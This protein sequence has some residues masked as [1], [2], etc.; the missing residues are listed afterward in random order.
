MTFS[1]PT[2]TYFNH[3]YEHPVLWNSDRRRYEEKKLSTECLNV[4]KRKKYFES[5]QKYRDQLQVLQLFTESL[6]SWKKLFILFSSSYTIHS[7]Q[8]NYNF[9]HNSP[10]IQLFLHSTRIIKKGFICRG[11]RI[12]I[13]GMLIRWLVPGN[14]RESLFILWNTAITIGYDLFSRKSYFM[15]Q[16]SNWVNELHHEESLLLILIFIFMSSHFIMLKVRRSEVNRLKIEIYKQILNLWRRPVLTEI[17]VPIYVFV[18]QTS[19][20]MLNQGR[21]AIPR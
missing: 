17:S 15:I 5:L 6:I 19:N 16:F 14:I 10:F 13:Q 7:H 2:T 12:L 20:F 21:N 11:R 3:Y 1:Y 4:W 8:S 9:V 18:N